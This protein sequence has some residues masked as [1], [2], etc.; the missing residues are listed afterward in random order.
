MGLDCLKKGE[1]NQKHMKTNMTITQIRAAL[2]EAGELHAELSDNLLKKDSKQA[3]REA[4][5][6]DKLG[7]PKGTKIVA[8]YYAKRAWDSANRDLAV[9]YMERLGE[10]G[11]A[12]D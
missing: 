4:L 11:D 12:E 10:I 5:K 2:K 6:A 7:C 8:A 1:R 9:T 3:W